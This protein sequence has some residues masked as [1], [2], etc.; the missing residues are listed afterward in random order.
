[1]CWLTT[2]LMRVVLPALTAPSA[3]STS[4]ASLAV[5][6]T[7]W[8]GEPLGSGLACASPAA[9]RPS[10]PAKVRRCNTETKATRIK[11]PYCT[12][13]RKP[14]LT[15]LRVP[16]R[17]RPCRRQGH[18]PRRLRSWAGRLRLPRGGPAPWRCGVAGR[19]RG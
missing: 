17:G 16:A 13:E 5:A 12:D 10:R 3:L 11:T 9:A 4:S 14:Q 19:R 8:S 15:W 1:M 7:N 2:S 18:R 6:R